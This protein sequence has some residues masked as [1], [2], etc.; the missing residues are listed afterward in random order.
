MKTIFDHLS[1]FY[2]KPFADIFGNTKVTGDSPP[3]G[4]IHIPKLF[5]KTRIKKDLTSVQRMI[6][7]SF[8]IQL[9][10][11]TDIQEEPIF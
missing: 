6:V 8:M 5:V 9:D 10:N 7:F 11:A 1:D 2:G 4:R 3:T